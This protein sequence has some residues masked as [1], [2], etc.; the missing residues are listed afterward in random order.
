M[1]DAMTDPAVTPVT[2]A[3]RA[4]IFAVIAVALSAAGH[5]LISGHPLSFSTLLPAALGTATVAWVFA[6]RQWGATAIIGGLSAM[7]LILHLWFGLAPVAN[8]HSAHGGHGAT[9]SM[10]NSPSMAAAHCLA[11]TCCG[12]WLW[13]G[14]R[15]L[16]AL[17]RALHA[18]VFAPLLAVFHVGR[19]A[20]APIARPAHVRVRIA[21]QDV[22]RHVLARRGPPAFAFG[23]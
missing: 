20:D 7:Q 16:F 17:L 5:S 15:A 1:S 2:R 11:A 10:V 22:L 3:V 19:A 18:R 8:G 23:V 21:P 12:L 13:W 4:A 14:E 9:P 6:D